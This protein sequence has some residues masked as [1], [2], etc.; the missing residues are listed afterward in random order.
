[1]LFLAHASGREASL[2][3]AAANR[4]RLTSS[5]MAKLGTDPEHILSNLSERLDKR[6]F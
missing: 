6:G 4:A 3:V 5:D 2:Y 1:M